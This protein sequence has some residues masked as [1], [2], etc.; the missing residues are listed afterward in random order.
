MMSRNS[1]GSIVAFVLGLL[2]SGIGTIIMVLREVWQSETN[3][4]EEEQV[5]VDVRQMYKEIITPV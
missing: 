4:F 2:F 5:S 1:Q 3:E